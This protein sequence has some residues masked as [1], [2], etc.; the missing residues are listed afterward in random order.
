MEKE[1]NAWIDKEYS[2]ESSIKIVSVTQSTVDRLVVIT[3]FY[4]MDSIHK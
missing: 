3:I 2:H 4:R 1:I